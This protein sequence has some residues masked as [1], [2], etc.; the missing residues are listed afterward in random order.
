M[1]VFKCYGNNITEPVSQVMLGRKFKLTVLFAKYFWG[2]GEN[3][4]FIG[5]NSFYCNTITKD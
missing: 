3:Y 4:D 1:I 2:G 5:L